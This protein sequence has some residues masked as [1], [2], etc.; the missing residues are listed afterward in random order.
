MTDINKKIQSIKFFYSSAVPIE[1]E[2]FVVNENFLKH[3]EILNDLENF[4]DVCITSSN[5]PFSITCREVKPIYSKQ[6][7]ENHHKPI[8]YT[9]KKKNE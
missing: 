9:F 7:K 8:M 5:I 6:I 3:N 2:N 1:L 4:L